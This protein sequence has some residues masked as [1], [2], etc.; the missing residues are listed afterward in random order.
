MENK[1][2]ALMAGLFTILLLIGAVFIGIWLNR[3]RVHWVPYLI[4]TRM[5]VPGLN[6][7]A[8][9]RYRGLDVGNVE[10]LGFDPKEAGK[11]LIRI[12]VQPDTP[13]T[14][15]TYATLGYQGVT[16]IA[17]VDLDDDGTSNVSLPSTKTKVAPIE[18]RPGI[19]NQ[20]QTRGLAILAQTEEMAKRINDM[21]EP[22]NRKAILSTFNNVSE[23]A[24]E[25]K[26]LSK[27]MQPTLA[28]L[29]ALTGQAQQALNSLSGLAQEAKILSG[30]LNDI[31]AQLKQPGG[32]LDSLTAS[33]AQFGAVASRL[34]F[35][36]LPLSTDVRTSMRNLNNTLDN[37]NRHP[38][39]VL[40]GAPPPV[41][42]PGESGF[43]APNR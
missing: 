29:P 35:D 8:S 36:L 9:V 10:S 14:Q 32:T 23:A 2:H 13:I 12:R 6:P 33:T 26:S 7:Q 25:I 11:I 27:Q 19:L 22:E 15:S 24:N 28:K 39:S 43:T 37:L 16:G 18:M 20:L 41:P 42:G 17:Y 3:D 5:S 38:D 40:F 1:A 34:E 21:L 31:S 30:N 4:A